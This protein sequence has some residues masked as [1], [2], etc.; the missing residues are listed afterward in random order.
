LGDVLGAPANPPKHLAFHDDEVDDVERCMRDGIA[1]PPNQEA[2]ATFDGT[3]VERPTARCALTALKAVEV[4]LRN[5][6]QVGPRLYVRHHL[7]AAL[8]TPPRQPHHITDIDV[9]SVQNLTS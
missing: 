7:A 5:E 2:G 1:A 9:T 4:S 8:A 6:D 3:E